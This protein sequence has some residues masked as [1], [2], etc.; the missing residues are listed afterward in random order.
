MGAAFAAGAAD[1]NTSHQGYDSVPP[2][3][4]FRQ[5]AYRDV[6]APMV[7]RLISYFG[8]TFHPFALALALTALGLGPQITQQKDWQ[9]LAGQSID[10][11]FKL[12]TTVCDPVT[13]RLIDHK[14][15]V[16]Y[17]KL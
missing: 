17:F 10:H 4:S 2:P 8:L 14:D 13:A 3:L 12:G 6:P 5:T 9:A 11:T 15:A 7:E 1:A 16:F